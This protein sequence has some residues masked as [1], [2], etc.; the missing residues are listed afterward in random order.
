MDVLYYIRVGKYFWTEVFF[1]KIWNSSLFL[2]NVFSRFK[3]RFFKIV[4][5]YLYLNLFKFGIW[6]IVNIVWKNIFVQMSCL[7]WWNNEKKSL[8]YINVFE[9]DIVQFNW[10]KTLKF[11]KIN[12]IYERK[13]NE[14]IE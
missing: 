13:I 10:M 14:I 2:S 11:K 9:H 1:M 7:K 4:C 6:E 3:K 5:Q 12:E 8:K